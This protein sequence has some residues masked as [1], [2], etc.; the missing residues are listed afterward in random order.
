LQIDSV[1]EKLKLMKKL[2][3]DKVNLQLDD[4]LIV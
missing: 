1:I 3:E 2:E 4:E